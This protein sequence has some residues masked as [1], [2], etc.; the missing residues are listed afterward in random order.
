MTGSDCNT[1]CFGRCSSCSSGCTGCQGE[2][3]SSC[4]GGCLNSSV[5]SPSKSTSVKLDIGSNYTTN[6]NISSTNTNIRIID[7]S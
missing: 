7:K 3:T 5:Y 4:I 2:C 6:C 1:S